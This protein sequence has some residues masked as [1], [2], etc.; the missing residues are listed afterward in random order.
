ME[1]RLHSPVGAEAVIYQWPLTSG[2]GS[3]KH[4]GALEIVETI[5]S[6]I[7][8]LAV[9]LNAK[10]VNTDPN[11]VSPQ[12]EAQGSRRGQRAK[13]SIF[14]GS[15]GG[16]HPWTRRRGVEVSLTRQPDGGIM[17]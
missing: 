8:L 6:K 9:P 5:R 16:L 1:L 11:I 7:D 2:R 3:D 14:Y 15:H 12:F 4:D 17:C 10:V 13:P